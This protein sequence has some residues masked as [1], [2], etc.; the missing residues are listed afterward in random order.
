MHDSPI[1]AIAFDLDGT[2]VDTAPDIAIALNAALASAGLAP[3]ETGRV[4]GWVGDGP[5]ALVRHALG[6]LGVS[7][8]EPL[9]AALGA[10][11]DAAT[12]AAPLAEGRVFDGIGT[13]LER[14]HARVPMVV[15]SNKPTRLSRSVL[16]AAGL[17][18][19]FDRLHCADRVEQRK[20]GPALLLD[21]AAAAG[22]EPGRL[23]MV[24]DSGNDLRA[25]HAAGCPAVWVAWGYGAYAPVDP[26]RDL[27]R[28]DSVDDL[29]ELLERRCAPARASLRRRRA[30]AGDPSVPFERHEREQRQ[31]RLAQPLRTV[32]IGQVDD[33]RAFDDRRAEALEQA[34]AGHHRAAGRDQVVD[35]HDAV[36]RLH[37]VGVHLD[38]RRAVFELVGFLDRRERQLALLADRH[39]ADVQLVRDDRADDEPA[40][41]EAGNDVRADV[42]IAVHELVDQD[43]EDARIREQRRDVAELHA[44]RRPVGNGAD[45]AAD[46]VRRGRFGRRDGGGWSHERMAFGAAGGGRIAPPAPAPD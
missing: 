20:P 3:V 32:Q 38:R 17:L 1:A 7:A 30:A 27:L 5:L 14:W 12:L 39:E 36:A 15:V 29:A 45:V 34:S 28:V 4:R 42:E 18:D 13:L 25:A 22:V 11:F 8:D 35:Q 10:A 37:R 19:R 2:L 41:V 40:R 31:P 24:G 21:A 16:A 44:R 9:V 33:R 46:V 43:A 6:H 26:T 23:L